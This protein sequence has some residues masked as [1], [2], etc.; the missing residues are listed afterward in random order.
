MDAA[1]SGPA[2]AF[3]GPGGAEHDACVAKSHVGMKELLLLVEL[4]L[5]NLAAKGFDNPIKGGLSIVV[6]KVWNGD[7]CRHVWYRERLDT[8]Y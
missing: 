3:V 5:D 8:C 6:Q 1:T 4:C 7:G 2:I